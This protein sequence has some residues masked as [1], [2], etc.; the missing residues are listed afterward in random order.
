[1]VKTRTQLKSEA[2]ISIMAGY[3]LSKPMHGKSNTALGRKYSATPRTSGVGLYKYGRE[4]LIKEG[5]FVGNRV[6][7][8]YFPSLGTLSDDEHARNESYRRQKGL[9]G[10]KILERFVPRLVDS[11]VNKV[12]AGLD[13]KPDKVPS[14]TEQM[15]S[16]GGVKQRPAGKGANPVDVT[17]KDGRHFQHTF[18]ALSAK[19]QHGIYGKAGSKLNSDIRILKAQYKNSDKS[20]AKIADEIAKRGLRYFK[21]RLPEWNKHMDLM[22]K[23]KYNKNKFNTKTASGLR[24][25]LAWKHHK[26]RRGDTNILRTALKGLKVVSDTAVGKFQ[27]HADTITRTALGNMGEFGQGVTYTFFINKYQYAHIS[28]FRMTQDL[29]WDTAALDKGIAVTQHDALTD[30]LTLQSNGMSDK[31][32]TMRQFQS[33]I[34]YETSLSSKAVSTMTLQC[35]NTAALK[36]ASGKIYPSIDIIQANKK[37]SKYIRDEVVPEIENQFKLETS[38]DLSTRLGETIATRPPMWA[39]PYISIAD[40]DIRRHGI[41]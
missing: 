32:V 4:G 31:E 33:Q 26:N 24:D 5:I 17:T 27:K 14:P 36:T 29:R 40:Y 28:R 9:D 35:Q 1:M 18:Q 7:Y 20:A 15:S 41:G 23:P 37:F 10:N 19:D 34:A 16:I 30:I 2:F 21:Q 38:G 12:Q 11:V 13:L 22:L 8:K 3:H 39:I 6:Y 25:A